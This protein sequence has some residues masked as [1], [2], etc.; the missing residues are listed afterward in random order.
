MLSI[1]DIVCLA[2]FVIFIFLGYHRGLIDEAAKLVGAALGLYIAVIKYEMVTDLFGN[3]FESIPG[4][5]M[6]VSFLLIFLVVYFAVQFV[7][8]LISR[9]LNKLKLDWI[10]KSLGG[11]FGFLKGLIVMLAIVWFLSIFQGLELDH[12]LQSSSVS[13]MFLHD[14]QEYVSKKFNIEKELEKMTERIREMF[15]LE[16]YEKETAI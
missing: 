15:M 16:K 13:Y 7:G 6:V 8:H 14:V 12:K 1:F 4:V 10:N 9:S 5:R 2:V 3:V 11:F